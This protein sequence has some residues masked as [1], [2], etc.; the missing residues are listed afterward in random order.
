MGLLVLRQRL[1]R[2]LLVFLIL[3]AA[4]A[5]AIYV[6]EPIIANSAVWIVVLGVFLLLFLIGQAIFR[7]LL[8]VGGD[9]VRR[10]SS[11]PH[12]HTTNLLA[13][14]VPLY[15]ERLAR[16]GRRALTILQERICHPLRITRI[17]A[18]WPR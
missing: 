8:C 7:A 14:W 6:N 13:L 16:A 18:G 17:V 3:F 12:G 9:A 5:A 4:G 1:F 15:R 11:C 10:F 2:F